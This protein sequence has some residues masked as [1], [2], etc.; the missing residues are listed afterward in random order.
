LNHRL[1]KLELA[2]ELK[3]ADVNYFHVSIQYEP[4][5]RVSKFPATRQPAETNENPEFKL[6]NC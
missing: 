4:S 1:L 3:F 6:P 5:L 2:D